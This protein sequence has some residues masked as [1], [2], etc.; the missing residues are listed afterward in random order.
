MTT[1]TAGPAQ[2]MNLRMV[3][4]PVQNSAAWATQ[5]IA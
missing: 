1:Y 5:R 3:S 4:M 2:S